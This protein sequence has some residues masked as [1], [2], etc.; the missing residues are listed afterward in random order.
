MDIN[1]L[2]DKVILDVPDCPIMTIRDQIRWAARDLCTR[3]DVWVERDQPVVAMISALE[4]EVMPTTYAEPLRLVS[5][6]IGER[7]TVQGP[8]W[9]QTSPTTVSFS[10]EIKDSML[11]GDLA[12]RPLRD[13]MP[14][15]AILDRWGEAIEDGARYR[16]LLMPQPWRNAEMAQ[17]YMRRYEDSVSEAKSS[18]RLG[19]ARG[20]NRVKSRRFI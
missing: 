5:L 11:Y 20:H 3:A 19:H 14:P 15:D 16:L 1:S 4:G 6:K 7:V 9:T 18:S 2:V 17:Y 13:K 8:E 12:V 10:R